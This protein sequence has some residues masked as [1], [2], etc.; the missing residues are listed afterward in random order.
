MLTL[1]NIITKTAKYFIFCQNFWQ[2]MKRKINKEMKEKKYT[3]Q[4]KYRE[5]NKIMKYRRILI[6]VT[7][8]ML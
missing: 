7:K 2:N 8:Q 1:L 6:T 5:I 3:T 4:H